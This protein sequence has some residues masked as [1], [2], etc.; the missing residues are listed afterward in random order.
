MEIEP[1]EAP[2]EGRGDG[3][4]VLPE[5]EEPGLERLALDDREVD[6]RL[7]EPARVHGRVDDPDL[8]PTLAQARL[9]ALAP[10]GGAVVDDP[11]HPPGARVGLLGHH[12]L[13]EPPEGRDPGLRFAS[14]K[15][16]RPVDVP[17]GEV[18]ERAAPLVLV[19]DPTGKPRRGRA[20]RVDP[21]P[22]LDARLLVGA[23]DV[24]VGSQRLALETAAIEVEDEPGLAL[25][26]RVT[27]KDPR[28][29]RPGLEGVLGEPAPYG[30]RA[31]RF[32]D[33][34]G[35]RDPG[36][37]GDRETGEGEAKISRSLAGE[38]LD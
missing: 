14:P 27:R 33:V 36:D 3:A 31:D 6:L 29:V 18:G 13:D 5:G 10:M 4:V 23:H 38:R 20:S 34:P 32:H 22:G 30:R 8:R 25:E 28:P 21:R 11:E 26:V 9:G 37:F 24:L 35:D 2:L 16:P 1:G 19:L 7:V 17:G 15:D 12:L